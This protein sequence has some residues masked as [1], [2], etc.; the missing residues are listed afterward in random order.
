MVLNHWNPPVNHRF[1]HGI[2]SGPSEFSNHERGLCADLEEKALAKGAQNE[3]FA[4]LGQVSETAG[5]C[6]ACFASDVVLFGG[7]GHFR[8]VQAHHYAVPSACFRLWAAV[9]F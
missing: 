1:D 8:Q 9:D 4:W 5:G 2:S 3:V 6:P 7:D